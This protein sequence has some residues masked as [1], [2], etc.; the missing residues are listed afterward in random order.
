HRLLLDEV[1]FPVVATSGNSSFLPGWRGASHSAVFTGDSA[2]WSLDGVTATVTR[3]SNPCSAPSTQPVKDATVDASRPD[4]ALGRAPTLEIGPERLALLAFDLRALR[5]ALGPAVY[6]Q[7][8]TLELSLIGGSASGLELLELEEPWSENATWHC[9]D[10]TTPSNLVEDCLEDRRWSL[11]PLARPPYNPWV[12]RDPGTAPVFVVNGARLTADV[13]ADVERGA[14]R[15][16]QRF[17]WALR[18]PATATLP[19][20]ESGRGPRLQVNELRD[21]LHR[22]DR[23]AGAGGQARREPQGGHGHAGAWPAPRCGS[24]RPRPLHR[25]RAG[26][27]D[28][29]GPWR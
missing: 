1:G 5:A 17:G 20:R 27:R 3:R 28:A 16:G 10:D 25:P 22:G 6:L 21:P 11:D 24:S 2:G 12:E 4:A 23:G 14:Y 9:A 19:S 15:I 13:T 7:S 29:G 8:A 26:E 18:S